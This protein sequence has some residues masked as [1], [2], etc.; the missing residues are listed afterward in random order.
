MKNAISWFEIPVTNYERA[1]EF[2]S[3]VMDSEITDH[4]IPEQN[5]KYGM[6]AHD[7]ANEGVG[8]GLIEAEGQIPTNDGPT[9][10][11]NG[12]DNLTIPLSKVEKA[13]GK[14][15]MP[16]TNIGE[17]GFM[18]QFVDTEGNRIALHSW[19]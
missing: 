9:I 1:K 13:G 12:G 7:N 18:A 8:G 17:N 10:Y 3:T 16:K 14:V 15:I 6:F 19:N 5:V 11:L 2:Y 4:H